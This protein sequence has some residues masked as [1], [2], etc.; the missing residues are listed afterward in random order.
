MSVCAF[1]ELPDDTLRIIF[2]FCTIRAMLNVAQTCKSFLSLVDGD[3]TWL[4]VLSK[5]CPWVLNVKNCDL[6]LKQFYKKH[7]ASGFALHCSRYDFTPLGKFKENIYNAQ[8][9][10]EYLIVCRQTK[11]FQQTE[12]CGYS[13]VTEVPCP[14][15]DTIH[16]SFTRRMGDRLTC[17]TVSNNGRCQLIDIE[18]ASVLQQY[19]HGGRVRLMGAHLDSRFAYSVGMNQYIRAFDVAAGAEAASFQLPRP[20]YAALCVRS[21]GEHLLLAGGVGATYLFD[22]RAGKQPVQTMELDAGPVWRVC[23]DFDA[24]DCVSVSLRGQ[25]HVRF[26]LAIGAVCSFILRCTCAFLP[27]CRPF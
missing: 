1:F 3:A 24:M 13:L 7:V 4:I 8:A 17:L 20:F 15:A 5:H 10:E 22:A 23:P 18:Q 12:T 16:D 21:S 6:S 19:D 26:I 27:H 25:V 9:I 11:I 14:P 2:S